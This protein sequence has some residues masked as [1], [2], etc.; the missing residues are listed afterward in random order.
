MKINVWHTIEQRTTDASLTSGFHES[1]HA[2]AEGGHIKHMTEISPCSKNKEIAFLVNIYHKF[3]I[4]TLNWIN[5]A[6][7]LYSWPPYISQGSVASDVNKDCT[8]K[9]KDKAQAYKDQ[10]KD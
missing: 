10:D 7:K 5:C 4:I 3:F 1:K 9:D 6:V 2:C 8:C